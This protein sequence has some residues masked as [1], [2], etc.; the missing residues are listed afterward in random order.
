MDGST[1]YFVAWIGWIVV[2]FFMKKE[3][4][5][6]KISA[7]ILI[8]II[9]SPLNVTISSFTVSINALLL[10]IISFVGITLYS[11]WKKLY[12]LLSALIIAM[13]YT[14]FHLLEVYDPIW[15]VVDRLL[16]LS[17]ALV[18]AS[19]LLY[20]DRILRLCTL[21]IGMLQGELLVTLI[22]HKLHFPYEYGSLAFFDV[23]A[24]STLF[25]A[26]LLWITKVS[27][28]MEQFK[29]KTRKRRARV[30]HD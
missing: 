16:L 19:I 5:R 10:C 15:I 30:I 3:P 17:G 7:C 2:T 23:V 29:R 11:I 25:M 27:V 26:I 20:G 9:C 13:L 1:F 22:F 28:Y 21:Y 8:F 24:V 6:W 14:S 18:Y 4:I 12:T